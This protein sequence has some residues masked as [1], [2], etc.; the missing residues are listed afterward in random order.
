M[1]CNLVLDKSLIVGIIYTAGIFWHFK[2]SI[3]QLNK[4]GAENDHKG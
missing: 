2:N 1:H 3:N 4:E